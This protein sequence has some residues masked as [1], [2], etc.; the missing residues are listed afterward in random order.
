MH[1]PYNRVFAAYCEEGP[2]GPLKEKC[3]AFSAKLEHWRKLSKYEPLGDFL[4]ALLT[5]SGFAS[6][7]SAV[8]AGPQRLANLRA[9]ADKAQAYESENAGGLYGFINYIEAI[10]KGGG[11]VD[12]GQVK[13]L[14]ESAPVVR[15]MSV[16]KSKG[17]EFPFVLLAGLGKRFGKADPS[18]AAFHKSFGAAL[19]L[20]DPKTGLYSE[21]LSMKMIRRKTAAESLAEEIRV[22]YVALTRPKD[23]ILMSAAV[24]G[25]AKTLQKARSAVPGDM[26]GCSDFV[27]AILPLLPESAVTVRSREEVG[28]TH[29][30]GRLQRADLAEKLE[31][32]FHPSADDLPVTKEEIARR[33]D[34]CY[35]PPAGEQEKRKYSVS[36]IAA[37]EREK[38]QELPKKL[39][40][41]E[42][43]A[44][45]AEEP[46]ERPERLPV[47]LSADKGLSAASR[48]TAYHTVMEHLPFTPEGKDP[49]SIR[50]FMDGLVEKGLLTP[51]ERAA[52][53]PQRVSAFFESQI[54]REAMAAGEL[55]KEAPFTMR[56]DLGG[57]QVLVQG[58]IDC[59]FRQGDGWVL[60]D[61]KSNYIDKE[62]L[63]AEMQRLRAEYL[64]QLALYREALEGVTGQTVKKAVLYCFGI[65]KEISIDEQ[66]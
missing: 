52:V 23:I 21:P 32:G 9:L 63:E 27:S 3:R 50:A 42:G 33:L 53:D 55:Y 31:H 34:F 43:D 7:A 13:I 49:D 44:P 36:Q 64:P 20:V 48:G 58:T 19:R 12:V 24:K 38:L 22:L 47:F 28:E 8:P 30:K 57:R 66:S 1:A 5:D 35:D 45:D 46:R 41:E 14:A 54:G 59:Y 65:D 11:K 4:W 25:A 17:L 60:V 26:E 56:H 62:N 16:H 2:D 37:M 40:P 6:F 18:K 61:Y 39:T 51:A 15:I 10:N 29:A